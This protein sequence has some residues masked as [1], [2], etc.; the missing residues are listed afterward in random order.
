LQNYQLGIEKS[1]IN[2]IVQTYY[3]ENV[4]PKIISYYVT[5]AK[6]GITSD[7]S[8]LPKD[9]VE[10]EINPS[11][12]EYK[13]TTEIE[14]IKSLLKDLQITPTNAENELIKLGIQKDIANLI[15]QTYVP[16]LY[17][18]HTIIGNIVNGQLFQSRESSREFRK[19]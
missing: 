3:L 10:Y 14:Y 17:S 12:L 11:I 15:V 18:L 16:T 6:H 2:T 13:I 1:L 5:L 9:I 8:K 7:V 19:C 4:Y